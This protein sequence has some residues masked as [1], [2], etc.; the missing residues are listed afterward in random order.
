MAKSSWPRASSP[1]AGT[2]LTIAAL[3]LAAGSEAPPQA[4]ELTRLIQG[5][6]R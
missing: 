1:V 3:L 5:G 6:W 4:R 2:F